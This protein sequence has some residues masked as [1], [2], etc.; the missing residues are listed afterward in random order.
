MDTILSEQRQQFS[1][2]TS[3]RQVY[4]HHCPYTS[5]PG[6]MVREV[7]LNCHQHV[8]HIPAHHSCVLHKPLLSHGVDHLTEDGELGWIAHP[9]IEYPET[10]SRSHV[11]GEVEASSE[12]LLGEGDEVWRLAEVE[13]LVH[14]ELSTGSCPGLNLVHQQVGVVLGANILQ[15]LEKLGAGIVVATFTLHWLHD[16][17]GDRLASLLPLYKFVLDL[18]Y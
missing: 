9:R 7:C 5:C 14:P 15:S 10:F 18:K 16:D 13:V 6:Y 4:G 3:I 11:L 2:G 1:P 8:Q 17:T 12:H